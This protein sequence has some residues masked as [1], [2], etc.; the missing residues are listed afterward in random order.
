MLPKPSMDFWNDHQKS[1]EN[2]HGDG[3]LH[4]VGHEH[5]KLAIGE[6]VLSS[7]GIE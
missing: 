4:I 3:V 5:D 6:E 1:P 2:L 7:E